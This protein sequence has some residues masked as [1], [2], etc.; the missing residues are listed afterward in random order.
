MI[1]DADMRDTGADHGT[2]LGK[3]V[4]IKSTIVEDDLETRVGS[5]ISWCR[6]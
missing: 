4:N 3:L 5:Q 2:L 6:P 1:A